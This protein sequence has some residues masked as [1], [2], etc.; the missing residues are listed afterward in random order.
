MLNFQFTLIVSCNCVRPT[1]K[2]CSVDLCFCTVFFLHSLSLSLVPLFIFEMVETFFS[3]KSSFLSCNANYWILFPITCQC[4]YSGF[5][6]D[7]YNRT[8]KIIIN[9]TKH[10]NTHAT[11]MAEMKTRQ[12]KK[13]I[14]RIVLRKFKAA[15][16]DFANKRRT[17]VHAIRETERENSAA[18][19]KPCAKRTQIE[20]T[21]RKT[22][23]NTT[24]EW[25]CV[26]QRVLCRAV[27]IFLCIQLYI[28]FGLNK[29]YCNKYWQ[30]A[31]LF[32]S[33]V[34][35]KWKNNVLCA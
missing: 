17:G 25:L 22:K 34:Y 15:K 35:L 10:S 28:L 27:Y 3:R 20:C 1:K 31:L 26:R 19:A 33:R 16:W 8:V 32:I 9:S 21:K 24:A 23:N 30:K 5:L 2:E 4:H 6:S 14:E 7:V 12:S 18:R 13:N 11:Q 29:Y